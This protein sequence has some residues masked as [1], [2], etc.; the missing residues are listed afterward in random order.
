MYGRTDRYQ[1]DIFRRSLLRPQTLRPQGLRPSLRTLPV[2]VF[3]QEGSG[4]RHR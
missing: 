4:L 2:A 1:C 3:R